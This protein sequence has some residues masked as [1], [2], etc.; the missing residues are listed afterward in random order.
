MN[1]ELKEKAQQYLQQIEAARKL[2]FKRGWSKKYTKYVSS[3]EYAKNYKP[4]DEA[5]LVIDVKNNIG[6]LFSIPIA[7]LAPIIVFKLIKDEATW[8]VNTGMF[9]TIGLMALI[10]AVFENIP[11]RW[12]WLRMKSGRSLAAVATSPGLD[13]RNIQGWPRRKCL[14]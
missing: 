9:L 6:G 3:I 1:N 5:P 14:Q 7:F 8:I 11:G 2:P 10:V 4:V 13:H 12:I